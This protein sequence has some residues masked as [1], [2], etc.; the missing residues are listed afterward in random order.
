MGFTCIAVVAAESCWRAGADVDEPPDRDVVGFVGAV[1]VGAA[2]VGGTGE[3]VPV[4]V[5]VPPELRTTTPAPT[6]EP[7][8]VVPMS[9]SVSAAVDGVALRADDVLAVLPVI[10]DGVDAVAVLVDEAVSAALPEAVE[11]AEL[12]A[13]FASVP[14]SGVADATPGL[15]AAAIPTPNATANP[16]TRPMCLA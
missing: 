11:P 1:K 10:V 3:G 5:C 12:A 4:E 16:P 9:G 7:V 13:L 14:V 15:V 6:T 8:C 2:T